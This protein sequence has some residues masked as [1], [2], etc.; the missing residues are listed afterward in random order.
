VKIAQIT[1]TV[2]GGAGL[3]AVRLSEAL[4]SI[5]ASA[6]VI[7]QRNEGGKTSLGSKLTTAFQSHVV[8]AGEKL[9]STFSRTEMNLKKLDGFDVLHFHAT[10]NLINT[11]NLIRLAESRKIF[12]TM[13]DQRLVTGGCHYSGDCLQFENICK[14]C[15]QT[16][17]SFRGLVS[18]EKLMINKLIGS[19]NVFLISPSS[20]L[21]ELVQRSTRTGN[22]ISIIHNPIPQSNSQDI[23]TFEFTRR[24]S[25]EKFVIGFVAANINNPAKGVDDLVSALQQ[26]PLTLQEK[27]HLLIVGRGRLNLKNNCFDYTHIDNY[28][29]GSEFNPY[30]KMNL[31]VVPSREDNSP[32]VIGEALMNNVRV[33]GSK[34]GGIP[35]LLEVFGCPVVDTVDIRAFANSIQLEILAVNQADYVKRAKAVFGYPVIGLKT[36]ELYESLL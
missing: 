3:A 28:I 19:K 12:I 22:Q 9:I 32:N 24:L 31:L 13:H 5:G 30:N 7:S 25:Q 26:L 15:P 34:I 17:K 20:W 1:T 27:V 4:N 14:G 2:N 35:E 11:K 18:T 23:N 6:S 29:P 21:A 16:N 33:L 36:L 8:Q 10:Y